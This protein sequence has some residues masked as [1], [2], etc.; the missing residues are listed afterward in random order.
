MT[1]RAFSWRGVVFFFVFCAAISAWTWSGVLFKT[2]S[3]EE[4]VEYF[5]SLFQ[6]S[7]LNYFPAFVLVT[8]ADGLPLRGMARKVALGAALFVGV[9]LAVQVRCAVSANQ[10]FYVYDSV[11]LPYCTTFPTWRTYLDFPAAF[12]SPLTIGAMVMIFIFTRRRDAELVDT[13]HRAQAGE[14]EARRQRIESEI[15]AM[16]A[17][18]DPDKLLETLR[19]VRGQYEAGLAE[20]EAML[21]ALIGNLREAAG[22][23]P[24][25]AMGDE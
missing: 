14:L 19:G 12:M 25:E 4:H 3:I 6:R 24:A 22:R 23:P 8:L 2:I 10:M 13:L 17:R 15:E 5:L 9:M 1:L 18:V 20:G 7:L 16:H 21:D 11:V